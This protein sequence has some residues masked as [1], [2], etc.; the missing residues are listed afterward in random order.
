MSSAGKVL[1]CVLACAIA[2]TARA[3]DSKRPFTVEDQLDLEQLGRSFGGA[4]AL[5]PDGRDVAFVVQRS[6]RT[7]T[8]PA[9]NLLLGND[10]ADVFVVP[11]AGGK[12]VNITQGARDDTGHWAP[13]WAPDGKRM[14]ML[15]TRGSEVSLWVWERATGTLHRLTD[16][17][18]DVSWVF[19]RPYSW[20]SATRLVVPV[21]SAHAKPPPWQPGESSASVLSS[22]APVGS[23]LLPSIELRA[24]DAETGESRV[25]GEGEVRN[26]VLSP[27]R[28]A[29]AYARRV[30]A[31]A[32]HLRSPF[33]LLSAA[34]KYDVQILSSDGATVL[35][36]DAPTYSVVPSS[37]RWSPDGTELAFLSYADAGMESARLTRFNTRTHTFSVA[38]AAQMQPIEVN[39]YRQN[40]SLEWTSQG[41]LMLAA[42]GSDAAPSRSPVRRDWWLIGNDGSVRN[43]THE[44]SAAPSTLWREAD[45][46]SYVGLVDGDLW[47]ISANMPPRNLTAQFA[48]RISAVVWPSDT[49]GFA[50]GEQPAHGYA[51]LVIEAQEG[52]E[53]RLFVATI[54]DSQL[55]VRPLRSPGSNATL[56]GFSPSTDVMLWSSDDGEGLRLGAARGR[57]GRIESIFESNTFLKAVAPGAHLRLEYRSLDGRNLTGWMLLPPHHKQGT[58]A[59]LVVWVYP[60]WISGAAPPQ[61]GMLSYPSPLNLQILAA[62]GYAVLRPSMPIMPEGTRDEPLLGLTASVL[63][64]VDKAIELGIAD[65]DR[66]F[67][68]GHSLGG[69]ATYGLITQTT[70]F[71]AAVAMAGASNLLSDYGQFAADRYDDDPHCTPYNQAR[72]IETALRLGVPPWADWSRYLRNSPIYYVDRVQTPLMMIHGDADSV[73]IE[74][75][76]EFFTALYRQGKR[77]EFV[78]YRGEGHEIGTA[79]NVRDMWQR[80]FRW[81]DEI[82][83]PGERQ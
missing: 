68:M 62:R 35:P 74:Q 31:R 6:R 64:A 66:L 44:L 73:P 28:S 67:V 17:G 11:V 79:A 51:Q 56:L 20:V 53:R 70:R 60:G 29:F 47:R 3:A 32:P 80:V 10:R 81:F 23:C 58:R 24:I 14:A 43:L 21:L 77:A 42:R 40:P 16:G 5:S 36:P 46:D 71:R 7:A 72:V 26:L 15:S 69:F 2:L 76:E 39:A 19:D 30:A 49:L 25:I 82:G 9:S 61:A 45:R 34:G 27:N 63:P 8:R 54:A 37:L 75:A 18:V 78:R 65:P 12:A 1:L 13:A 22:A 50:S 48:P 59:P 57:Q 38:A 33:D 52:A 83:G 55:S 41:W 4:V